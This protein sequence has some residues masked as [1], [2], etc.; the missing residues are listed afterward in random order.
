MFTHLSE[1]FRRFADRFRRARRNVA[2]AIAKALRSVLDFLRW[3]GELGATTLRAV[4]DA[5]V[6]GLNYIQSLLADLKKSAQKTARAAADAS[7]T[8]LRAEHERA[9]NPGKHRR[10]YVTLYFVL[11]ILAAVGLGTLVPIPLVAPI[12]IFFVSLGAFHFL[13]LW[14]Y[15]AEC[16]WRRVDYPWVLVAIFTVMIAIIT[17]DSKFYSSETDRIYAEI[18]DANATFGT[19][20]GDWK[21]FCDEH[22]TAIKLGFQTDLDKEKAGLLD[23]LPSARQSA[24]TFLK[25]CEIDTLKQT[26]AALSPDSLVKLGRQDVLKLRENLE[27]WVPCDF[28]MLTAL[29]FERDTP[30]HSFSSF[31]EFALKEFPTLQNILSSLFGPTGKYIKICNSGDRLHRSLSDLS[32]LMTN[33]EQ[34]NKVTVVNWVTTTPWHLRWWYLALLFLVGLRLGKVTAEIKQVHARRS[35]AQQARP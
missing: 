4:A 12:A 11:M 17:M 35:Q 1:L 14:T 19:A 18:K 28:Q 10:I 25:A 15:D 33:M 22:L 20:I 26:T 8:R 16:G 6:G 29:D 27:I 30:E 5:I 3:L 2:D 34:E 24:N 21:N 32:N 31:Q 13:A 23:L 9:K 7:K